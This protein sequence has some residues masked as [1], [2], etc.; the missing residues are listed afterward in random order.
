MG[1]AWQPIALDA[2]PHDEEEE[3]GI[4]QPSG[5]KL[6]SMHEVAKHNTREDCWVVVQVRPVMRI[7]AR[8]V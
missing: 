7:Q 4:T 6:I 3:E 2:Q 1:N 8:R 5:Q